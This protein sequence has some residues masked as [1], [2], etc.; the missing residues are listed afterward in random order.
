MFRAYGTQDHLSLFA[1]DLKSTA[2][3]LSEPMALSRIQ[4]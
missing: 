3:K 4:L 2:R 1:V